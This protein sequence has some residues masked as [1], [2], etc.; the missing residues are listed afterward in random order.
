MTKELAAQALFGAIPITGRL[1]ITASNVYPYGIGMSSGG[2]LRLQ[3]VTPEAV[4]F[5]P[6]ILNKIDQ[7]AAEAIRIKATPGCQ[8]FVAKS[9]KVIFEKSYGHHTY[10]K[11]IPVKNSDLYDISSI[12]KVAASTLG[13]MEMYERGR[14]RLNDRLQDV[15]P[16]VNRTNKR[17]LVIND[18]LMHRSGLKGWIPFY[19]ETLPNGD[20]PNVYQKQAISPYNVEVAKNMYMLQNHQNMVWKTIHRSELMS[21]KYRYSD[22]GFF[23]FSKVIENYAGR[24]LDQH[25]NDRYYSSLGL[26]TMSYNP[27]SKFSKRSIVPTENDNYWRKQIVHG[28]VHDMGAAMMGGV[29][30]HAGLFSNANDLGILMQMLLN[31]GNYGGIQYFEP[32]T[33]QKF[34]ARQMKDNRRGLGFDKPALP[35]AKKSAASRKASTK[36]FGHTGFTGTCT[37][38][39]PD[40]EIVYVFLSNRVYPSAENWKLVSKN[41]RTRIHDV[42]YEANAQRNRNFAT[43]S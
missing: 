34:T 10:G 22:L 27:L 19:K 1:P 36:T 11:K 18:M 8:V 24:P 38:V 5:N 2:N 28:H 4:G 33:I 41:I 39:D 29:G 20:F 43:R 35:T 17:N 9:G 25:M 3:Y 40:N 37:W 30:G 15:L 32:S 6:N 16:E 26:K 12:T 14:L 23:Y 42:I 13:V 21:K 31:G 7:I